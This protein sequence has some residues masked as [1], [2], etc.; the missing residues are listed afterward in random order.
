MLLEM[1]ISLIENEK[2]LGEA[3]FVLAGLEPND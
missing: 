2:G 3:G 1:R